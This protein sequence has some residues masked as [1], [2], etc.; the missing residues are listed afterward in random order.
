MPGNGTAGAMAPA[1]PALSLRAGD[2]RRAALPLPTLLLLP[3][4]ACLVLFYLGPILFGMWASVQAEGT[5]MEGA[6]FVGAAHYR[7]LADDPRFRTSLW[8]TVV[9]TLSTV[10]ATYGTGLSTAMLLQRRFPGQ[11][12]IGGALL[13]PWTMPLV[14]VAVV[15]AWLLD[16][17]FGP[18]NYVLRQLGLIDRSLGFLTDPDIALWSVG[19]AQVWR[20]FP[21]AMVTL[22]AALK[23]IPHDLYEAAAID[24]ATGMQAFRHITLPG[25]RSTTIALVLLLAIWAFGRAFT[26]IFIM[27]GGGPAAATETLVVQTY[28]EAFRYFRLE[29]ASALGTVVLL[30]SLVFTAFYL[31]VRRA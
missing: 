21:L 14:V 11:R 12:F 22:L 18:V 27:T 16:Y 13:V 7:S 29:R 19:A 3:I 9:F 15:W 10:A 23:A 17:Q 30:L 1:A 5:A 20:L 6:R 25:L 26:I 28:L 4:L 2:R 24:G 8:V 31:R